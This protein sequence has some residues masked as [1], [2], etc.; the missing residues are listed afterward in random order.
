M[1]AVG[2]DTAELAQAKARFVAEQYKSTDFLLEAPLGGQEDL[3]W[4]MIPGT[5]TS[6]IC[7]E[8]AQIT[9]GREF[10]TGVPLVSNELGDE[11]GARFGENISTARHTPILRDADGSIQADTSAS[12]GV[13]AEL[14][15]GKSVLL[16]CDMG[17]TV[18]RNGRVVAI[19][20]TETREYAAFAKSLRPDS[21]TVVDLIE[22]EYSLDPLRVFGPRIGARMVQS[23]FATMLGIRARDSRGVMLGRLLEPEYAATHA[24]TS[25]RALEKH[26]AT[27][28]S[29]E[30]DELAGLINLVSAKDLGEVLFNDGLRAVDLSSRA[31]VF[32]THGLVLPDA[33]ELEHQHLFDEMPL[34]K[35]VGRSMY[36]MLMGITRAVCF[37]NTQELAGAYFDETHHITASPEGA[38]ELLIGLREGRRNRAFFGL[39]SHDPAD[40]GDTKTRG[41]IKTRYVMRQTDK[42]LARRAIEWLTG[43][44]ADA[45]MVKVVTEEL[46]PLGSDGRVAPDRRGEGLIRDQRGR[47]GKFRRT[48]PERPDR[49]EA[50][51][52]TPSLVTP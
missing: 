47:I 35:I 28:N 19:D 45:R 27:F 5:A 20:R 1:F 16:K 37:M 38:R 15:A 9:T 7:R 13:V 39:G 30:T 40:F 6:R 18:D 24:L 32:L 29:P 23:L 14:G 22:P 42:E 46:S 50:V 51:L 44:P 33:V 48:L 41:L 49:R 4:S 26:V 36:A 3:W 43:E 8:L 31:F 25:L 17:D 21:T 2:A 11:R 52:S 34:E 12:F 10:A